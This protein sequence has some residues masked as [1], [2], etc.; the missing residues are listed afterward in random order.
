M[1]IRQILNIHSEITCTCYMPLILIISEQCSS[2][3]YNFEHQLITIIPLAWAVKGKDS[4]NKVVR[5]IQ[6]TV[7]SINFFWS[8]SISRKN[9]LWLLSNSKRNW[10]LTISNG[11]EAFHQLISRERSN[12]LQRI[13]KLKSFEKFDLFRFRSEWIITDS[14]F[15]FCSLLLFDISFHKFTFRR[16]WKWS[17]FH[18]LFLI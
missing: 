12:V 2:I 3:L 9:N 17:W 11:Q 6:A 4:S 16:R 10:E 14:K 15:I 18:G 5:K 1:M 13:S 8:M 7:P